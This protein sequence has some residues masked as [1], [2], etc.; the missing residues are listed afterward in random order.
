[1]SLAAA[2]SDAASVRGAAL[3]AVPGRSRRDGESGPDTPGP[4]RHRARARGAQSAALPAAP[5]R[6][7]APLRA[8][9]P[10]PGVLRSHCRR[11]Q[12]AARGGARAVGPGRAGHLL[13][14][15]DNNLECV[16][17]LFRRRNLIT[18][19]LYRELPGGFSIRRTVHPF[20][21]LSFVFLP[22]V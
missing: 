10:A 9:P 6:G 3:R 8:P 5:S 22:F 7:P 11:L 21:F 15:L 16:S 4:G 14:F 2:R 20:R 17:A 1:M 13:L 19:F 18:G 12:A